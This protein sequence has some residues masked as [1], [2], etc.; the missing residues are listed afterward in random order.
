MQYKNSDATNKQWSDQVV[1]IVSIGT[2]SAPLSQFTIRYWF[3]ADSQVPT[4]AACYSAPSS[5]GGCTKVTLNLVAVTP[6]RPK[7]SYYLEIGFT[8]SAPTLAAGS[9][10]LDIQT[11]FHYASWANVDRTNDY[12]YDG[13][14]TSLT[15]WS[16]VTL[17]NNGNKVWGNEPPP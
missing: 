5:V 10:T 9:Q 3:D 1:S 14:K 8:S 16:N 17:Y 2:T 12:S 13:T 15:D 11:A 4:G 6:A 7:A